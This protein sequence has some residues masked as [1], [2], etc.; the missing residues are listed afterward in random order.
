[1]HNRALGSRGC[2]KIIHIIS[3]HARDLGSVQE[4]WVQAEVS[5]DM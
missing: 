1:M 2:G 3:R 4:R 5:K